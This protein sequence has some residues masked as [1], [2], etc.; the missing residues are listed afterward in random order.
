MVAINI[1]FTSF[2]FKIVFR[3]LLRWTQSPN[4]AHFM[5]AHML[6]IAVWYLTSYL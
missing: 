2:H 1:D 5:L 6:T 4:L 3:R